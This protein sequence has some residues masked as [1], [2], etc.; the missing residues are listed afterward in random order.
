MTV[1]VVVKRGRNNSR[2]VLLAPVKSATEHD[3]FI[4]K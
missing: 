1:T 3:V 2:L 4:Y